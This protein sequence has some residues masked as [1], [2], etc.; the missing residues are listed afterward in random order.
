MPAVE[1]FTNDPPE[2]PRGRARLGL[3]TLVG[4]VG[5][6][7]G[8]Y[9]NRPSVNPIASQPDA[10]TLRL[11]AERGIDLESRT[12]DDTAARLLA[13]VGAGEAI[14][15]AELNS[16]GGIITRAGGEG[17]FT[18]YTVDRH[19]DGSIRTVYGVLE[20]RP[21]GPAIQWHPGGGV[22]RAWRYLDGRMVGQILERSRDG[23]LV[24]RAVAGPASANGG[25][26]VGEVT[27]VA[28]GERR[29][30]DAGRFQWTS[31]GGSTVGVSEALRPEEI[32]SFMLFRRGWLGR[33]ELVVDD[34]RRLHPSK[35]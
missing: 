18:G 13:L 6:S 2:A 32:G 19:P 16:T 1:T 21:A 34:S 35:E 30:F 15:A 10:T 28:Y 9:V 7:V 27:L 23:E 22:H 33:E 25:T 11:A 3:L 4:L 12:P 5:L 26:L 31:V 20:G 24:L 14:D 17:V 8:L 29:S